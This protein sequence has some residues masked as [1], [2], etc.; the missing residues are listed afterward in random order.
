FD[1]VVADGD[2]VTYAIDNPDNGEWE[3]GLGV[4]SQSS[5]I[6]RASEGVFASSNAG[7][8]VNFTSGTESVALVPAALLPFLTCPAALVGSV[9]S[10]GSG[11]FTK[12]FG[13]GSDGDLMATSGP[14]T[15]SA[16]AQY[17]RVVL[18]GTAK[19]NTNGY[20]LRAWILD[21]RNAGASAIHND[22]GDGQSASGTTAGKAG[23][24]P[25]QNTIGGAESN[26]GKAG[27]AA[28]A[29]GT[30]GGNIG[31]VGGDGGAGGEGGDAPD[32]G[33]PQAGG[34]GGACTGSYSV[35]SGSSYI[36]SSGAIVSAFAAIEGGAPGGS[37]GGSNDSGG[38]AGGGSGAGGGVVLVAA[39]ILLVG[40][41]TAAGAISAH[42]GDGG[43]GGAGATGKSG[44]GGGGGGGGGWVNVVWLHKDGSKSG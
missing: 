38:A 16:N 4:Y 36:D 17:R 24:G 14:T 23:A 34:S 1:D 12:F 39:A 13:N 3:T 2:A 40:N 28:K 10:L 37:G 5:G 26:A 6:L 22:G 21:L 41:S 8:L 44:G 42:G 43:N 31:G 25:G 30:D 32:G 11:N 7:A 20:V 9:M 15:L 27:A 29:D 18:T 19:I 35:T 33:D